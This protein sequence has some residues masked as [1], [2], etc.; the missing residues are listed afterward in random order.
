MKKKLKKAK[1]TK[2]KSSWTEIDTKASI[3]AALLVLFSAM[4]SPK[5]S[6]LIAFVA[7]I[8]FGYKFIKS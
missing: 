5:I 6:F 1:T 3:F 7:I 2:S 4:I 8:Y